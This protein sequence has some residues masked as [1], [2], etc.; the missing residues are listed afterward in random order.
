MKILYALIFGVLPFVGLLVYAFP[1][2]ISFGAIT[3]ITLVVML[4]AV[5]A[6]YISK[7]VG[8]REVLM[9]LA[10]YFTFLIVIAFFILPSFAV[11]ISSG[12]ILN[13]NWW[14]ALNWIKNNTAECA[15][16]ATYWDPGHFITG[17][18]ERRVIY[19]GASQN[20]I[21]ELN[22]SEALKRGIDIKQYSDGVNLIPYDKGSIQVILKNDDMITTSRMKDVAISMYT[23][24]ESL[25]VDLLKKYRVEGCDEMYFLATTDLIGKSTWWTY[26]ATWD[27]TKDCS[28]QLCKGIPINY[29]FL[30]LG[31]KR[32]LFSEAVVGYEYPLSQVQSIIIYIKNDTA[33]A[34]FQ[35]ENQFKRISNL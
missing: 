21:F 19:D 7:K 23:D 32:P 8:K 11:S 24:N 35:S 1:S 30:N 13:D 18:S 31:G 15:V 10:S 2:G 16:I 12:P 6:L 26:F 17:I 33:T 14:Q 20:N 28:T 9:S 27:P 25:A 22:S 4:V 3:G 5:I 29:A 34:L